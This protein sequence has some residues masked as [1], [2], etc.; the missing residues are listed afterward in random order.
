MKSQRTLVLRREQLA[1]LGESDLGAVAGAASQP[2][3]TC[4]CPDASYICLTGG[5]ICSKIVCV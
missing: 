3:N 4:N 1:E 2:G 5:A